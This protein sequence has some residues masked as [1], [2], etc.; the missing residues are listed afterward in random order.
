MHVDFVII[1]AGII[2]LTI[3]KEL[4][5][6]FPIA[7][8]AVIEKE[9]EVG[10]HA[11][12]R[13]SG[14]MHAGIYYQSDSLK[15]K[16]CLNGARAMLD[17]CKEHNLPS[18]SIGKIILPTKN[19]DASVINML[20]ERAKANGALV[21]LINNDELKKMEPNANIA[22][23]IA[24]F[25]PNTAVVSP[26]EIVKHIFQD[27]KN[28]GVIFYF[29]SRCDEFFPD[30]NTIHFKNTKIKYG[31]LFNTAGLYADKVAAACGLKE[32]FLMIPFKGM[33][34][35]L[36]KA[37]AIKINHLIYPVPDMNVPFL[38]VHFTKSIDD[39]VYI[40]P[41]AIPVLGREHYHGLKGIKLTETIEVFSQISKLYFKNKQGFRYYAHQEIPRFI[42][43]RFIE[44][45][46]AMVPSIKEEDIIK[47]K[48]VGIRAQLYDKQ[49]QELAMDFIVKSTPN[50]TH[51][52]NAVSPAFTSSFSFAKYVIKEALL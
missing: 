42:K 21:S 43:S 12:G 36:S 8:I 47:S 31:H 49:K 17:Y 3:A 4:K 2:G 37:S 15:A 9:P 7:T 46:K 52:L 35:E 5:E 34:Y 45:A 11:S 24:L 29:N 30:T 51:V 13:N 44:S 18:N 14:I 23:D 10:L 33:Y 40:G 41:T 27:L 48:K 39:K 20:Y 25:S 6:Q 50:A 1:G 38:G 28:R 16:F 32:K 19:S 22:S 26:K